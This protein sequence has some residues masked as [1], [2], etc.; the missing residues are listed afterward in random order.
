MT[1][2]KKSILITDP[3]PVVLDQQ[4]WFSINNTLIFRVD[5]FDATSGIKSIV[6]N[7]ND[8]EFTYYHTDILIDNAGNHYVEAEVPGADHSEHKFHISAVVTDFA[9]NATAYESL[10]VYVDTELPTIENCTVEKVDTLWDKILRILTFGIYSNDSLVFHIYTNDA[11]LDSGIDYATIYHNQLDAPVKMKDLGDGEF[12][13]K[14]DKDLAVFDSTL[15]IVVYD[16]YGNRSLSCT[17]IA[18]VPTTAVMIETEVPFLYFNLPEGDG[19]SRQDDQVWYRTTKTFTLKVSDTLSGVNNISLTVNGVDILQDANQLTLLKSAAAEAAGQKNNSELE[20]VFHTDYF[21]SI[22]GEPQDGKYY[23]EIAVVDNAGNVSSKVVTYYMD[24]TPPVIDSIQFTPS[25]VTGMGSV[26]DFIQTHTYGL[27]FKEDFHATVL[28]SDNK[29]SSGLYQIVYRLVE[30]KDGNIHKTTEGASP[31]VDG[32]ADI[33]IPKG[34]KGQIFVDAYDLSLNHLGE[35]TPLSCVVDQLAP[36]IQII[37]NEQTELYDGDGQPL[38]VHGNSIT[39]V[40]TDTGS[41]LKEFGYQ[42]DAEVSPF[43]RKVIA[44]RDSGYQLGEALGDGWTV[45]GTDANLVTQVTKTFVFANDDNNVKLTMDA[46]DH[47]LNETRDVSTETFTVDKTAP[48]IYVNFQED[49]DSDLYYDQDRIAE[50][51]VIE[52]NFDPT[53]IDILIKNTFGDVPS[54][55]FTQQSISEYSTVIVFDEGDYTFDVTGM[56]L[57][58]RAAAVNFTGG[59]E[60]AFYVDK[61]AAVVVENFS[62]FSNRTDNSFRENKTAQIKVT[63]HHFSPDLMGLRILRKAAGASHNSS[64]F[65]DI[66][67]SVMKTAEWVHNGDEH[68]ISFLFDQDAVYYI[69]IQPTDPAG[70]TTAKCSTAIFEIDK[71][72]PIVIKKN[73]TEV[74]PDNTQFLDLYDY[75][76]KDAGVPTVEFADNNLLHIR[77]TLTTYIPSQSSTNAETMKPNIQSGTVEGPVFTLPEFKADGIYAIEL[78]AVDVAGNESAVN[79]NTYARMVDR[80]ILAFIM[81]SDPARRTGLYSLEYENGEPI[82]KKPS[83]FEDLN[84]FILAA[85]EMPIEIVLRDNNGTMFHT[86][87]QYEVDESI[88]GIGA[89]RYVLKADYFTEN[90]QSDTDAELCLAVVNGEGLRI[91]LADI[92]IDN[93]EPEC[94]LPKGFSDWHWF[95]SADCRTFTITNISEQLDT[96]NCKVYDNG[97]EIPFTF[98]Q[99]D[100]TMTFQLERGW[101][102]VGI[103]LCDHAGNSYNIQ[104]IRNVHIGYFW[105]IVFAS[106]CVVS[107]AI[108]ATLIILHK[109]KHQMEQD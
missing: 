63:E 61:T 16:R 92:H 4:Q 37:S 90:F 88:Y 83:S 69:E 50:I 73:G 7:V 38:Y 97:V 91:D 45:T 8:Q 44:L 58:H 49:D 17:N 67:D 2:E 79:I 1:P 74:K 28:V 77:Y 59:N 26:T 107:I 54:Y 52:R 95:V 109:K 20:Y 40:I 86:G 12:S 60:N 31:I 104:E 41:G 99:E 105:P 36:Q 84:I 85:K 57:G 53:L 25:T 72:I 11:E 66:T 23:I 34:F 14:I 56:D 75:D 18:G 30:Y 33:D 39:V 100:K 89:Y 19:I 96:A 3:E 24:K 32:Q 64:K 108:A 43:V 103:I 65:T 93:I 35:V 13:F 102:N 98:S 15:D 42:L 21:T 81:D 94:T 101:H 106:I 55:I 71:T 27:Y 46:T 76:R 70:N 82:S 48:I 47:C 68:S 29:S 5:A 78:V 6:L 62:T 22:C 80:D 51:T 9:D 10:L 87:A